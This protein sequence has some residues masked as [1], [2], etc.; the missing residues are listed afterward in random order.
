MEM[1]V[2]EEF[3]ENSNSKDNCNNKE[4]TQKID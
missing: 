4:T 1:R 3:K 2:D